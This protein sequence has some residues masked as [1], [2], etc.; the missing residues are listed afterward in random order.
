MTLTSYWASMSEAQRDFARALLACFRELREHA[1][2]R[3]HESADITLVEPRLAPPRS[4]LNPSH[5]DAAHQYDLDGLSAKTASESEKKRRR[6][7]MRRL[8]RTEDYKQKRN[9]RERRRR[10][11]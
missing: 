2:Q 1:V 5:F 6:D 9:A 4:C 3:F 7:R 8:R 11:A 10:A